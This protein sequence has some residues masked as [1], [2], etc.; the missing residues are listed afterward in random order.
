MTTDRSLTDAQARGVRHARELETHLAW[1][2]TFSST[3]LG[4]LSVAS[5]IY[6][7]LGVSSLLDD[8]G[9][10]S[11]FAA[12]AY[13]VAVSVGI[14]VFWSYMMR[15]FPAV[16]SAQSR[17]GLT[18]AMGLGSLAIV[19]MSSWL[20]AA[21]LAG[22]AAVE[23]HLATTVQDYQ[24]ALEETHEIALSAQGLE[25]DVARVRQSF[26]D[27]SEQEAAGALSGLA[28]R[29]AVFRVLRQKSAELAGL[30]AQIA[31]QTPLV[32]AAFAEG[33]TILSR[34]RALTVEAGPVEARSV[35]FSEATVRLAGLIA[36]L[37]QLSV[38]PLVERAAQD[39]AASV[40]L[41]ELDGSTSQIRTDQAST[42]TSVLDVLAQR[43]ATLERAA[44]AVIAQTPPPEVT[45]TPI[46]SADAVIL[47][48]RN[49]VPSWAGAIAI[50]LLPAVLVFILAITHAAIRQGREGTAV[51]DTMTLAE[52]RT[53]L[54]AIR[55][56]EL[57]MNNMPDTLE[58][59]A[60]SNPLRT[61]PATPAKPDTAA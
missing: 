22:S 29:G 3:A 31:T 1:L 42:I 53:A 39:L 40:V 49:F 44:A 56:V 25:R 33:N 41:P 35:E 48:A 43:A 26:E 46:S 2:D 57:A 21:A 55:D 30:E 6:T 8:T 5:G 18:L 7:Y 38:A 24:T 59:E 58:K 61:L 9:A 32:S 50:D 14:F 60:Q 20:N 36:Q 34:M 45:Y 27:L 13:S 37:R 16:R 23:Q 28:G 54:G 11:V 19:A 4:V 12:I 47:Y 17:I 10:M 51:D 15:L 52:L